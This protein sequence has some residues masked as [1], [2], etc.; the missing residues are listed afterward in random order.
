VREHGPL[1]TLLSDR[2]PLYYNVDKLT[3]LTIYFKLSLVHELSTE[4]LG[5]GLG[6]DGCRPME[7]QNGVIFVETN[8]WKG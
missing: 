5:S 4:E 8:P 2:I 7:W 1:S 3:N 6:V